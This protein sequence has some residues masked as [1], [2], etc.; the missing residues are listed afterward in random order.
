MFE[1]SVSGRFTATH[2]LRASHG[3]AEMLHEHIWHVKVTVAGQKL[4]AA[5]LLIDFGVLKARLTDLLDIFDGRNLNQV[6]PFVEQNPSAENL[7]FHLAEQL[8]DRLPE[9][10]RLKC[11]EVEEEPG[12]VARYTPTAWSP[13]D[14]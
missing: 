2:Q 14:G 8:A 13:A 6:P 12:C 9:A 5:G 4:D 1:L 7:A 10:V 11:V 3:A